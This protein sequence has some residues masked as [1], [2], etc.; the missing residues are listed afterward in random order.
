M[1]HLP[2]AILMNG[3]RLGDLFFNPCDHGATFV[4]GWLLLIGRRH[5]T[6]L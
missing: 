3:L 1:Y 2:T 4:V 6:E 5:F